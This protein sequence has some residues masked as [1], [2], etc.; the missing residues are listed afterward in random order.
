MG[1]VVLTIFPG[2]FEAGKSGYLMISPVTCDLSSFEMFKSASGTFRQTLLKRPGRKCH[3]HPLEIAYP[4]LS[5]SIMSSK[6]RNQ[7]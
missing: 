4:Y 2:C 7:W 1:L 6:F 5:I 3:G